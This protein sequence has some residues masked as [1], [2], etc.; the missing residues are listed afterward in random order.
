MQTII[1]Q[2]LWITE[3]NLSYIQVTNHRDRDHKDEHN[4]FPVRRLPSMTDP[5]LE[6]PDIDLQEASI[7]FRIVGDIHDRYWTCYTFL[8]KDIAGTDMPSSL[9]SGWRDDIHQR[10]ILEQVLVSSAIQTLTE[11]AE[12]ILKK[13]D[14][15]LRPGQVSLLSQPTADGRRNTLTVLLEIGYVFRSQR[16]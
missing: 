2:G 6:E 3:F 4:H 8:N 10:K 16:H 1:P 7:G 11:N 5:N 13:A 9:P 15:I 12:Q 14:G